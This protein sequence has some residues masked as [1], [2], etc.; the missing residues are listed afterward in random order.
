MRIP[1]NLPYY[2]QQ[3]YKHYLEGPTAIFQGDRTFGFFP[4]EWNKHTA[5]QAVVDYCKKEGDAF[6]PYF[7]VS[8]FVDFFPYCEPYD[9]SDPF[10]TR[11]HFVQANEVKRFALRFEK[12]VHDL[13][14]EVLSMFNGYSDQGEEYNYDH[15]ISKQ[16]FKNLCDIVIPTMP[17]VS[18]PR[19][20]WDLSYVTTAMVKDYGPKHTRCADYYPFYEVMVPVMKPKTFP[21]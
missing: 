4:L 18:P 21:S 10:S 12:Q 19:N 20:Q 1:Y 6:Y 8:G 16:D 13:F 15:D 9:S 2:Y 17:K 14:T 11:A 3:K 5:Y 7:H